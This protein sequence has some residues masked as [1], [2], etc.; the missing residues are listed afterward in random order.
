[1]R[2]ALV[3]H[4]YREWKQSPSPSPQLNPIERFW[5]LLRR[6]THNRLFDTPAD[7]RRSLRASLNPNQTVRDHIGTLLWT[8]PRLVDTQLTV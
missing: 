6:A 3:N 1:M 5:K 7:L 8:S 4:P 2:A